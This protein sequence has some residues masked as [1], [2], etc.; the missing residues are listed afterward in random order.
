MHK[1]I[2]KGHQKFTLQNKFMRV[3]PEYLGWLKGQQVSLDSEISVI[4]VL[5]N[6]V[7]QH[8]PDPCDLIE[9]QDMES[10][11]NDYLFSRADQLEQVEA[12]IKEHG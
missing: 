1:V 10:F 11:L 9:G 3:D 8:A 5:L 4:E 6:S 7:G 2:R 12:F